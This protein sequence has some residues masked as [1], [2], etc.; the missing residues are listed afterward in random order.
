M[1]EI[2]PP[3]RGGG[4][5]EGGKGREEKGGKGER[6][7]NIYMY[8]LRTCYMHTCTVCADTQNN[9][10]INVVHLSSF[11]LSPYFIFSGVSLIVLK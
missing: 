1:E 5:G 10:V 3:R 4:K 2:L 7:V 6:E 9:I 11:S 8:I